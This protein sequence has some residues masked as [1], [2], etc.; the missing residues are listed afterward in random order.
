MASASRKLRDYRQGDAK[1]KITA[2]GHS[3]GGGLTLS[4]SARNANVD[5]VAF[6]SSPRVF[7]GLANDP[8]TAD[9]VLVS[10]VGDPL[11]NA[12]RFW[13]TKINESVPQENRFYTQYAKSGDNKHSAELL[14]L[15]LIR[16]GAKSNEALKTLLSH[17]G[18]CRVVARWRLCGSSH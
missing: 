1:K 9:R 15:G 8:P 5:A 6:N 3:L 12:R 16:Q 4:V 11:K 2:T 13:S 18:K 17:N 7:D 10:E 14:A